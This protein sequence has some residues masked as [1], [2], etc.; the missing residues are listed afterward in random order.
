MMNPRRGVAQRSLRWLFGLAALGMLLSAVP[1]EAQAQSVVVGKF[2]G[3][4]PKVANGVAARLAKALKKRGVKIVPTQSYLKAAKKF[5]AFRQGRKAYL[6]AAMKK[7]APKLKLDA[8]ITGRLAKGKV[9]LTVLGKDGKVLLKKTIPSRNKTLNAKINAAADEILAQLGAA[10]LAAVPEEK[11]AEEKPA[12]EKPAA[13]GGEK[14]AGEDEAMLP[15][16]ASSG[17]EKPAEGQPAEAQPAAGDDDEEAEEAKLAEPAKKAKKAKSEVGAIPDLLISVGAA[18]NL[19][20]GLSPRHESGVYPG[21]HADLRLFLDSFIDKPW[22][23]D[24]GV[25]G[26]FEMGL[27]LKYGREGGGEDWKSTQ[28]AWNAELLYRLAFLND[29]ILK[30]AFL[31]RLGFGNTAS[32][33]DAGDDP[34]ARSASYMY[35][36]ARLEVDLML[37]DPYL[38]LNLGGGYFFVVMAD[39][40]SSDTKT[41]SNGSGFAAGGGIDVVLFEMIDVGIGYEMRQLLGFKGPSPGGATGSTEEMSDVYQHIFLRVGWAFH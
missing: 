2:S 26:G 9:H 12:E 40:E 30:P 39:V 1:A 34:A 19:R 11:P 38:R 13:T 14:P 15:P 8:L 37:W 18:M 3:K 23:E 24:I 7:V 25:G 17:G 41:S 16:W 10:P 35:P 29:V 33:I 32:T 6:P 28:Y 20:G 31:V 4:P 27:G 36:Y 21:L 5:K 22:I